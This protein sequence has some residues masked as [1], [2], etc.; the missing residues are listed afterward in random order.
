MVNFS[1]F[2]KKGAN[3]KTVPPY[4]PATTDSSPSPDKDTGDNWSKPPGKRK[5]SASG[6]GSGSTTPLGL[7]SSS[8]F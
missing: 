2:Q 4:R 7:Y 6:K 5:L 3:V 8:N 1:V